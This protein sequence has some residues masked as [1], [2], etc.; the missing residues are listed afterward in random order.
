MLTNHR[1]GA[2]F[3]GLLGMISAFV[4]LVLAPGLPAQETTAIE[5]GTCLDCHEGLDQTLAA[6]PHRLASQII[7]PSVPVACVSCHSGADAHLENPS[8]ETITNPANLTGREVLNVCY[9]CHTPHVEMDNY[10]FDTHSIQEMNC[11]A[12]HQVHGGRR[13]LLVDDQAGFC[14][15]C[16]GEKETG[17]TGGS[18]HP[19]MQGVVSCL[20]C[21][22]FATRGDDRLAYDLAGVC[23]ACHPEQSGPFLYE[24]E[25]VNAYAMEGGGCTECHAPHGSGNDRLLKQPANMICRQCHYPAGHAAAHGGIWAEYDCRVCHTETHG[26]FTSNLYLDANLPAKLGGDCYNIGCHSLNR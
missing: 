18:A 21:H 24:H 13:D 20:D 4:L 1:A 6:T 14:L 19:V 26:S 22:R 3:F 16:H 23:R 17:F 10:G 11:S 9:T 15:S 5:D 12:C 8:R 7:K 2:P 25:A